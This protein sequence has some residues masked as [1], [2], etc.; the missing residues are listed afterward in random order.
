MQQGINGKRKFQIF[1]MVNFVVFLLY[2][3]VKTWGGSDPHVPA[4]ESNG[5]GSQFQVCRMY[6]VLG[7][8]M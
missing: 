8:I 7:H 2:V 3:A 4:L 6:C 1:W 5:Q